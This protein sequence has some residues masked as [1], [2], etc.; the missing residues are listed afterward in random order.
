VFLLQLGL[1]RG[2]DAFFGTIS[3]RASSGIRRQIQV[4]S[5]SISIVGMLA[6]PLGHV[7]V[8]VPETLCASCAHEA[9]S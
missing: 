9:H 8:G 6:H 5:M 4:G 3:A 7:I 1:A 2:G